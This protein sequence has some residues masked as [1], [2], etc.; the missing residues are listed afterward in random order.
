M[1][2]RSKK[3]PNVEVTV[4]ETGFYDV[5]WV[6]HPGEPWKNHNVKDPYIDLGHVKGNRDKGFTAYTP[7]PES[8]E[9]GT[10]R[11]LIKAAEALWER[12]P[13]RANPRK[14]TQ[15]YGGP[16][17]GYPYDTVVKVHPKDGRYRWF[18]QSTVGEVLASGWA[19]TKSEGMAAANSWI[20]EENRVGYQRKN[21]SGWKR[22]AK[23][24]T[25]AT[26]LVK[27]FRGSNSSGG[28]KGRILESYPGRWIWDLL[29]VPKGDGKI[30][31]FAHGKAVDESEAKSSVEDAYRRDFRRK[32]A[33]GIPRVR[34]WLISIGNGQKFRVLA[35][36]KRLAILNLREKYSTWG[37]PIK[38]VGVARKEVGQRE[39]VVE[40]TKRKNSS[41]WTQKP[42]GDV[43]KY[44]K[45]VRV[46]SGPGVAISAI[47]RP[48][49]A[50]GW[51][52]IVSEQTVKDGAWS[53]LGDG[54][55][56]TLAGAKYDADDQISEARK[57]YG[58][59]KNS[60]TR[61]VRPADRKNIKK[62]KGKMRK[63][64]TSFRMTPVNHLP[65]GKGGPGALKY[66][67]HLVRQIWKIV[68]SADGE[69]GY[70][71]K[72]E[73]GWY[74]VDIVGKM[75]QHIPKYQGKPYVRKLAIAALS[76]K[77]LRNAKGKR[78]KNPTKK[79]LSGWTYDESVRSWI[80]DSREY[81]AG[82]GGRKVE[83]EAWVTPHNYG[84]GPGA[85]WKVMQAWYKG[86]RH[87]PLQT[88]ERGS[89]S[90]VAQAK[91][92]AAKALAHHRVRFKDYERPSYKRKNARK[93][94]RTSIKKITV[95]GKPAYGVFRGS[96]RVGYAFTKST[97]NK[98]ARKKSK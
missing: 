85:N 38:S 2:R 15:F 25:G 64:P 1:A 29:K 33:R 44:T 7:Y 86:D 55:S 88:L 73:G 87:G 47:V 72:T 26:I 94:V 56:D 37:F 32:N 60:R 91:K 66:D 30:Q 49:T 5:V 76:Q 10:Y 70:V 23:A 43:Y 14:S 36:T 68:S 78:R 48:V 57:I 8:K 81:V 51:Y 50:K 21:P 58:S 83:T 96:R 42:Y 39:M 12:H 27:W 54:H 75:L 65:G 45:R 74:I 77:W 11:G 20:D 41:G 71:T 28:I 92:E 61:K 95:K 97:A 19:G 67:G 31:L 89:A 6:A 35:P 52:W 69:L 46:G 24:R 93:S 98:I 9:I 17:R 63:N 59:R 53:R 18:V 40:E 90:T 82:S 4:R 16:I 3:Y 13:K 62:G 79:L 84:D 80:K 22:P 34:E